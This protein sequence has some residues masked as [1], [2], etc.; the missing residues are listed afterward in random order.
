VGSLGLIAAALA[1]V[2]CGTDR[3][4]QP[5]ADPTARYPDIVSLFDHGVARTC[6]LNNGVCH[7]SNNFP[8]LHTV[9]T[10]LATIDHPCNVETA[11]RELVND[12]CEPPGDHLVAGGVDVRIVSAALAPDEVDL[13]VTQLT[14]V[15]VV[16]EPAALAAETTGLDVHR[17]DTVF[18]IGARVLSVDGATAV[19]DLPSD[20]AKRFFDVRVFPPGPLRVHE[21]DPNGNGIEGALHTSM[22]LI[23]A[24]DPEGSY[25]LHRLTD[26]T[27]GE[28]MP[29]QCRTWDDRAN[30]ALAC[31][32]AGL[33][34]DAANA[35]DPIDYAGCS[36]D[37]AGLGK[38]PPA[39][40]P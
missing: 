29:R 17:G 34:P 32:I 3:V 12:V 4:R 6:A 39:D 28:L 27:F 5:A 8:D 13:P 33:T 21:G 25:L 40:D 22:P 30:Q 38:C 35:Y 26:D 19:L 2:A 20:D 9:S 10:L 16:V 24:G 11:E 18:A 14:R 7:N 31:W 1:V 36:I 37:V 23:A 15:I